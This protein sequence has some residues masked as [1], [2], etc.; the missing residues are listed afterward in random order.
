MRTFFTQKPLWLVALAQLRK[1]LVQRLLILLIA[2]TILLLAGS[3]VVPVPFHRPL[4]SSPPLALAIGPIVLPRQL[5][6]TSRPSADL[7]NRQ[8]PIQQGCTADA[9]TL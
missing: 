7:C 9:Q 5:C 6:S 4:F 8:D 1:P 2:A 3:V